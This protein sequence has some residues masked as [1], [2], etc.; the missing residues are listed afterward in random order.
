[1]ITFAGC[2]QDVTTPVSLLPKADVCVGYA[3]E[4]S[5]VGALSHHVGRNKV[6]GEGS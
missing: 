2:F 5:L 3:L 4:G 6:C 1:V